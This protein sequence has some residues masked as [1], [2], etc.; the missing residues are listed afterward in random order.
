MD[1]D[2]FFVSALLW[3]LRI[4]SAKMS[5]K[6]VFD[7]EEVATPFYAQF[8]RIFAYGYHRVNDVINNFRA[9]L[10]KFKELRPLSCAVS[11]I[12]FVA[13]LA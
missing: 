12:S 5:W 7:N 9:H 4:K 2:D 10:L 3:Y 8:S 6:K 11:K 13:S 1:N